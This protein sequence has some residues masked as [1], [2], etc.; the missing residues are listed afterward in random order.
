MRSAV[1]PPSRPDTLT[2]QLDG[3]LLHPA[4][5]LVILLGLLVFIVWWTLPRRKHRDDRRP[6]GQ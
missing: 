1:R 2:G 3:I 5:G 4:A 6:P